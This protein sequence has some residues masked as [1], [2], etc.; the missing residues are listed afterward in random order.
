[1]DP[2][3]K[4][5]IAVIVGAALFSP[6]PFATQAQGQPRDSE[7]TPLLRQVAVDVAYCMSTAYKL[8]LAVSAH[9]LGGSREEFEQALQ[10]YSED[11][12]SSFAK[13]TDDMAE[14]DIARQESELAEAQAQFF[15]LLAAAQDWDGQPETAR[16]L[17]EATRQLGQQLETICT[18]LSLLHDEELAA[19]P[20]CS[21]VMMQHHVAVRVPQNI[22]K[23]L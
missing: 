15:S 7:P 3:R 6:Y 12:R 11:A 17:I 2:A 19:A 4:I 9:A 16:R 8:G 1:M 10:G 5:R 18:E 14:F 13:A 20:R 23:H 22:R 21:N